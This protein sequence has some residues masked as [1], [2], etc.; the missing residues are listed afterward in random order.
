MIE[1]VLCFTKR[2][3]SCNKSKNPFSRFSTFADIRRRA[4]SSAAALNMF[5]CTRCSRKFRVYN[6]LYRH[7]RYEC[8]KKPRFGC[9]YC[10][11]V[12]K[13]TSSVYVHVKRMHTGQQLG[14]RD[15]AGD[16]IFLK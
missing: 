1:F 15:V 5:R 11:Y 12:T 13:H 6:S 3:L 16:K 14:Y 2:N 9:C 7:V 8:G 10:S 4:A